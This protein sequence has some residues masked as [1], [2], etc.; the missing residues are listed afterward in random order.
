[1]S[2]AVPRSHPLDASMDIQAL[3]EQFD[4][5]FALPPAQLAGTRIN[6]LTIRVG[7][8]LYAI[9][10]A[11]MR[12]LHT[13]LRILALPSAVPEFLGVTSI[14]GQTVPV[15]D[16]AALLG[17]E[18]C[19]APRWTVIVQAMAPLALAFDVFD[20]HL[21]VTSDQLVAAAQGAEGAD[22]NDGQAVQTADG[23]IPVLPVAAL[24]ARVARTV[25]ANARPQPAVRE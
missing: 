23:V 19:A 2:Q 25:S 7:G 22:G 3:R 11:D 9:R 15:Y 21:C 5:A 16:L 6:L 4:S 12:G 18:A 8:A 14:R 20:A 17:M 13:N 1:M 24:A 10:L